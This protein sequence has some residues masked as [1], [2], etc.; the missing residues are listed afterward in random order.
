MIDFEPILVSYGMLTRMLWLCQKLKSLLT[1]SMKYNL[2]Q[3]FYTVLRGPLLPYNTLYNIHHINNNC[4]TKTIKLK[5]HPIAHPHSERWGV[6]YEYPGW[7]WPCYDKPRLFTHI[8]AKQTKM[9]LK[10]QTEVILVLTPLS[11]HLTSDELLWS[12]TNMAPCVLRPSLLDRI[13]VWSNLDLAAPT[14][15][16]DYRMLVTITI[17]H[18]SH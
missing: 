15:N 8:P 2:V 6:Y 4:R 7:N 18:I 9:I 3:T 12:D 13:L 16:H 10:I 1:I 14:I 5:K 17:S 11:W